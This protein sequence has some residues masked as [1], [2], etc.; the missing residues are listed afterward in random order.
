MCYIIEDG[1][2]DIQ[3]MYGVRL[4][5]VIFC[6]FGCLCEGTVCTPNVYVLALLTV[7]CV[8]VCTDTRAYSV[9]IITVL[10]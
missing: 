6:E 3:R 10:L 7:V 9:R 2:R 8:V 5:Q 4:P 1:A